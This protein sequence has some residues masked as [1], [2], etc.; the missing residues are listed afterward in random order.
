MPAS[1]SQ[2]RYRCGCWTAWRY[3][4][5]FRG[6]FAPSLR[7]AGKALLAFAVLLSTYEVSP[8]KAQTCGS[9]GLALQVLGSGGPELQDKRASTSYLLWDQGINA[10]SLMPAEAA[11][12]VLGRAERRCPS[13]ILFCSAIFIS[14]TAAIFPHWCFLPGL[15]TAS[16]PC[17]C[18][19]LRGTNLCRPLVSLSAIFS[20]SRTELGAT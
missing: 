9:S 4:M 8:L 16:A 20:V 12:Y 6:V 18:T 15:K 14:I 7:L 19:A 5:E 10:S 3:E 1:R 17:R 13:W 11:H 2:L